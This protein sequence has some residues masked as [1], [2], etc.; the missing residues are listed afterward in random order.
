MP[1]PPSVD[2]PVATVAVHHPACGRTGMR[3]SDELRCATRVI[4]IAGHHVD[5]HKNCRLRPQGPTV[6]VIEYDIGNRDTHSGPPIR[7][8]T[9]ILDPELASAPGVAAGHITN[10]GNF[11][12]ASPRSK[13]ANAAATESRAHRGPKWCAPHRPHTGGASRLT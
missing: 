12:P 11:N 5:V 13:P 10:G 2:S 3:C 9:T 7:L 8:I 1:L 6:R 4:G